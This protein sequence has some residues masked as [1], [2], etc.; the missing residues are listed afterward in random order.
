MEIDCINMLHTSCLTTFKRVLIDISNVLH[1]QSKHRVFGAIQA[2]WRHSIP[3]SFLVLVDV[4]SSSNIS[5]L[6]VELRGSNNNVLPSGP[7][8][9]TGYCVVR[10]CCR[11]VTE[12]ESEWV[13]FPPV[14]VEVNHSHIVSK[15]GG[16]C[17][18]IKGVLYQ[19]FGRGIALFLQQDHSSTVIGSWCTS[20]HCQA[21]TAGDSVSRVQGESWGVTSR[22]YA[23]DTLFS[24]HNLVDFSYRGE[25]E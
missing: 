15:G 20:H 12:F 21:H 25:T 6:H 8:S 18:P 10:V 1:C 7:K 17:W 13:S 5:I 16:Q 3:A 11:D 14:T 24:Y 2:D 9:C 19:E 22:S 4:N 23:S